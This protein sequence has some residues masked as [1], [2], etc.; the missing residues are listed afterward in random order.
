MSSHGY[1]HSAPD[2]IHKLL[3]CPC[4]FNQVCLRFH[5]LGTCLDGSALALEMCINVV[6]EDNVCSLLICKLLKILQM[7]R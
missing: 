4:V 2:S 6:S 3:I 5:T 7:S 1:R